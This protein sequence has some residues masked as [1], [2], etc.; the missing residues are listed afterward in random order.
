M[1]KTCSLSSYLF[2]PQLIYD[3]KDGGASIGLI[4]LNPGQMEEEEKD[5][6]ERIGIKI[7]SKM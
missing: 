1:Q 4:S 2:T 6:F 5:K 3:F 7:P